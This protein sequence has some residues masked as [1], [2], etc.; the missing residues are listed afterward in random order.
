[1]KF[2]TCT[3]DLHAAA[4]LDI[5]NDAI[6]NSTALYDYQPRT[7]GN[8]AEWFELKDKAHYP[9]V[10]VVDNNG[11]LMGFASY[12]R[13]RE[14]PAFKYTIEHSIYIHHEFRG[15][16]LAKELM[17]RLV[18][19]AKQQDYHVMIGAIDLENKGSI[20]LHQKLGFTHTGTINQAGYKFG[21]W[22]DLGLFQLI[23]N[24]PIS[25][26]DG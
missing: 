23:L 22:L 16:G 15:K 2:I 10:G 18:L 26:V 3:F 6:L 20:L 17:S 4:I 8:M 11:Q 5:F 24:T 25:P 21:R 1:M 9:V 12:G 13:F 7:M 19:K 14:Q